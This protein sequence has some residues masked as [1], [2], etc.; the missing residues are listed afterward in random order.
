[1]QKNIMAA[2]ALALALTLAGTATANE[3]TAPD[4]LIEAIAR[5]ESSLNPLAVN[6]AGKSY[7]PATRQEA[8][9][10]IATAQASG[11]SFDVGLMQVNR[12]WIDRY[13]IQAESLLDPEFNRKWGVWI[14]EQA[15]AKHGL[16]WRAVGRYHT[17][18][19]ERGQVYAWRIFNMAQKHGL[20]LGSSENRLVTKTNKPRA[21][22]NAKQEEGSE[23]VPYRGTVQRR[24]GQ[25]QPG[26]IITFAVHDVDQPGK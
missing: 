13:G 16:N 5:Q 26:R 3:P 12:W 22:T 14:L 2:G 6:V 1:M 25:R 17:P 19:E 8:E 23:S 24:S 7:Q 20:G 18:H 11:K 21:S 9:Q 4:W 15:I 10:I